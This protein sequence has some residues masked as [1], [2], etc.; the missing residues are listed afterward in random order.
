MEPDWEKLKTEF[1]YSTAR[2][3]GSGGQHVNKVETKVIVSWIVSDSQ[4]FNEAQTKLIKKK[5]A[6]RLSKAGELSMYCQATRSQQRN[7][8]RV[9]NN[10]FRLIKKALVVPKKRKPSKINKQTKEKILKN[11]RIRS[12][13]KKTRQKPRLD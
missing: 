4:I 7:K 3:G 6:K 8:D 9:T 10:F 11:K 13:V 1:T 12:E 5:Y 2:S